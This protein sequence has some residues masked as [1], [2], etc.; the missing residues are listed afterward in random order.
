MES[1]ALQKNIGRK[2]KSA[3]DNRQEECI[4]NSE[5]FKKVGATLQERRPARMV[6]RKRASEYFRFANVFILAHAT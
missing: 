6:E 1:D 3:L 4:P 2:F 5:T